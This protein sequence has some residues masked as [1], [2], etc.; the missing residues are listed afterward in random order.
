MTASRSCFAITD[1]AA[2][3][4]LRES[5]LTTVCAG[6]RVGGIWLPSISTCAI[7]PSPAA[8]RSAA[9]LAAARAMP[10]RVAFRM[11]S[12]SITA[13][14]T[15]TTACRCGGPVSTAWKAA[16]RLAE[17]F[18]ESSRPSGRCGIAD[19]SSQQAAIVTGPAQGPRPA[20]STPITGPA[21]PDS[22]D[23]SGI[24]RSGEPSQIRSVAA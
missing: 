12:L 13:T 4:R 7:S 16:R 3:L 19:G 10:S 11:P 20:S 1:A 15:V 9:R 17:S 21:K 6:S 5:P 18:L 14:G 22:I 23:R 24:S 2:M 8:L